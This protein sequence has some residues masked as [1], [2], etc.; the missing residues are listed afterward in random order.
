MLTSYGQ[1]LK[2]T[3]TCC[4]LTHITLRDCGKR[5]EMTMKDQHRV[6]VVRTEQKAVGH[7][8]PQELGN[9]VTQW[10]NDNVDEVAWDKPPWK[11]P[12]KPLSV[13]ERK[14]TIRHDCQV[15][16]Q[17]NNVSHSL[18]PLQETVH[19]TDEHCLVRLKDLIEWGDSAKNT[20]STFNLHWT[21]S[22]YQGM[23]IHV[24]GWREIRQQPT[25]N[26][27]PGCRDGAQRWGTVPLP[28][29]NHHTCYP[30]P[31][32]LHSA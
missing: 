21:S 7:W 4:I 12:D 26:E 15:P 3:E 2:W 28:A 32:T 27:S 16:C 23:M 5:D 6:K 17:K 29:G 18:E 1:V 30:I 22:I 19:H 13:S 11:T 25:T 24:I 14:E 31:H 8:D 20:V 9:L 10:D